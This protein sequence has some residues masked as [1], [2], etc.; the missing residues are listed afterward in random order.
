MRKRRLKRVAGQKRSPESEQPLLGVQAMNSIGVV[1]R[2][3]DHGDMVEIP[4]PAR[5][6][7]GFL[8]AHNIGVDPLQE[9]CD[10]AEITTRRIAVLKHLIGTVLAAVGDI[11][12]YDLE[13]GPGGDRGSRHIASIHII[14]EHSSAHAQ[15]HQ[16]KNHCA[17]HRH[18]VRVA[19][20]VE[21]SRNLTAD[22]IQM[23]H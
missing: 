10:L 1:S 9:I 15:H 23:S 13:G 21:A 19:D 22:H 17:K 14:S 20:Q 7:I 18:L 16:Q 12:G 8:K 11:Q 2:L 4:T 6:S 5:G 3:R